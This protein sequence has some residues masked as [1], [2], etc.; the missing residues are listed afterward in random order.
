M[1]ILNLGEAEALQ[2]EKATTKPKNFLKRF[3]ET[4]FFFPSDFVLQSSKSLEQVLEAFKTLAHEEG[5][6]RFVVKLLENSND[7][8]FELRKETLN[9]IKT[10]NTEEKLEGRIHRGE[11]GSTQID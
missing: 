7:W 5:N 2:M 1:G 9:R 4:F 8:Q 10:Y 6:S 3:M 11:A